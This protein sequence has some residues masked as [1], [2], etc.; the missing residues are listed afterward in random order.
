MTPIPNG[1]RLSA[2]LSMPLRILSTAHQPFGS[3]VWLYRM[4]S[5]MEVNGG[6]EDSWGQDQKSFGNA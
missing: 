6:T 1:A 2:G 3:S 4:D 5:T